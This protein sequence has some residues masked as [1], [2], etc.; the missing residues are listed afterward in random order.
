MPASLET[1]YIHSPDMIDDDVRNGLI[2]FLD[3]KRQCGADCMA[4]T[5]DSSAT[6]SDLNVQQGHCA[7]VVGVHRTAKHLVIIA[8]LLNEQ[9]SADRKKDADM[10]RTMQ[11]SPP[12]PL[13]K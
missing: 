8:N 11:P 2:C 4:Y 6:G 9:R 1:P 13:G 3:A 5:T 12:N 10:K 7:L